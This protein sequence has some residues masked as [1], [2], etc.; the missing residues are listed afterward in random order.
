MERQSDS[1]VDTLRGALA[2]GP[3]LRLALLFGSHARG[4][5]RPD[6]DIDVGI[7]PIDDLLLR[8]ELVLQAALERACGRPVHLV[9]LDHAGTVL[10]WEAAR[11][12]VP[13]AASSPAEHAR[14]VARAA[15]EHADIAPALVRAGAV[16]R[17][18]LQGRRKV[19]TN[20]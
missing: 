7:L 2:S 12:G 10:K 13:V 17:E 1:V 19:T 18:R 15:L 14:F 4:R 8:E 20:P 3:R 6:S 16:F 9:R 5:A 11:Y